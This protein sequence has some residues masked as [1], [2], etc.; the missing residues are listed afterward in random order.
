MHLVYHSMEK[1]PLPATMPADLVPPS[2]RSRV[3]VGGV[4]VLPVMP[5][6][7]TGSSQ[8]S[9]DTT[10]SFP[11]NAAAPASW[12]SPPSS[13]AAS[14]VSYWYCMALAEHHVSLLLHVVP[15]LSDACISAA[16]G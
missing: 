14:N 12:S 7:N 2:H 13:I 3:P 16:W 4:P 6:L 10:G 15:S 1:K 11:V 5:T 9:V 8:A